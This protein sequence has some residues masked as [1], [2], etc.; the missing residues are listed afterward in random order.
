MSR[1][2]KIITGIL[3]T[4]FVMCICIGVGGYFAL[5][6]AGE[7]FEGAFI[8]EPDEVAKVAE[9]IVDYDLPAGYNEQFGMSFFGFDVVA[10]GPD[11]ASGETL[12]MLMQFPESAGLSE[13]EMQEQMSQAMEGQN[14][15]QSFDLKQV[16]QEPVMIRDQEVILNVSEGRGNEGEGIRQVSG[17]FE[18]K[19][20]TVFLMITGPIE[21]WD[22]G[23]V[24]EF[25]GSI[26]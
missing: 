19:N 18:G 2:A 1:N 25:I 22:E 7:A 6:R 13:E 21:R 9:K 24:D 26:R 12:I 20:G 14:Q 10:F 3:G 8:T 11:G 15:G 23:A 4:L 16:A 5:Q 17:V